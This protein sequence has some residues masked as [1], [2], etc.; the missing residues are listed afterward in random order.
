[1]TPADLPRALARVPEKRL[2]IFSLA[3]ELAPDGSLDAERAIQRVK[4]IDEAIEE[5][6]A[7]ARHTLGLL[8]CLMRQWKH[9]V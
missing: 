8:Q 6:E 1:M 3:R 9:L 2:L 4:E 5:A 7:Y